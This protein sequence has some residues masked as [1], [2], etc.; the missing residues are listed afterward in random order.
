[1]IT[2]GCSDW[3]EKLRKKN[4]WSEG[5][6]VAILSKEVEDWFDRTK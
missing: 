3:D 2:V 1:M 5:L 6:S 4:G